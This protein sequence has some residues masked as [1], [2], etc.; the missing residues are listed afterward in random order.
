[1]EVELETTVHMIP[2]ESID[3]GGFNPNGRVMGPAYDEFREDVRKRGIIQAILVRPL[4]TDKKSGQDR[5]F[6]IAGHRRLQAAID[7]M[8]EQIPAV[9]V[10]SQPSSDDELRLIENIQRAD[11]DPVSEAEAYSTM[12]KEFGADGPA[13]IAT[14]V[15]KS[16][17]H[18]RRRLSLLRVSKKVLQAVAAGELPVRVAELV[19]SV[20]NEKLR[21]KA[22]EEALSFTWEHRPATVTEMRQWLAEHAGHE[23]SSAGWDP[24]DD[25]LYTGEPCKGACVLCPFNTANQGELFGDVGKDAACMNAEGWAAKTK[26]HFERRAAQVKAAGGTVLSTV[27]AK[28]L[29]RNRSAGRF[30][31]ASEMC[32]QDSKYRTYD[33]LAG[34][35]LAQRAVGLVD[36]EIVEAVDSKAVVTAAKER[37]AKIAPERAAGSRLSASEKAKRT[38]S[39]RERSTVAIALE[40]VVAK[41]EATS[42]SPAWI[43]EQLARSVHH[44][45]AKTL[46]TRRG[47]VPEKKKGQAGGWNPRQV[48]KERAAALPA[49]AAAGVIVE[50]LA[51]PSYPG[52]VVAVQSACKQY[53]INWEKLLIDAEKAGTEKKAAKKTTK[54]NSGSA[55][56]KSTA[57]ARRYTAAEKNAVL[58]IAK[59]EA[60]TGAQVQKRFGI[61]PVT[62]YKWRGKGLVEKPAKRRAGKQRG[63]LIKRAKKA[64]AR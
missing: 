23:L 49:A 52:D 35:D 33:Q 43:L 48:V 19:G 39:Q 20:D 61:P 16:V 2:V 6:L 41:A 31:K 54:P 64:K 27:E 12:V 55:A 38:K 34:K 10:S 53:G 11:L 9:V 24:A 3:R 21:A 22:C 56:K 7:T 1:M 37:G 17:H 62:F 47:W 13:E 46:C 59:K 36:G 63:S 25:K 58:N 45:Q 5:Y 4:G 32:H 30:V 60:L 18:V 8:L 14:R 28:A 51:T 50:L 29:A 15:G 44:E 57:S 42:L 26:A 40:K